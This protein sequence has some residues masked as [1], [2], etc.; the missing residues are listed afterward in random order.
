VAR[1]KLA[2][3]YIT[4]INDGG[5]GIVTPQELPIGDALLFNIS[6]PNGWMFDLFGRIRHAHRG[7]TINAYNV[8]FD[9]GQATFIFNLF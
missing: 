5:V 2:D 4:N 8:T 6:M 9:P 1:R 3:G 7:L